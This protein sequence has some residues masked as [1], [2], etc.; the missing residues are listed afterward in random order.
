VRPGELRSLSRN[1]AAS[2]ADSSEAVTRKCIEAMRK[3]AEGRVFRLLSH[4][5]AT[6]NSERGLHFRR[7]IKEMP[8]NGG[9][10]SELAATYT[11]SSREL[12]ECMV[13]GDCHALVYDPTTYEYRF[14]TPADMRAAA[15]I[16]DL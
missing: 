10:L 3:N 15:L 1:L 13:K 5:D 4:D 11:P 2:P 16:V 7:L 12:V 8:R 6:K 9:S 14:N